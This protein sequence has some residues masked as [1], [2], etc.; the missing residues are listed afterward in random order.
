MKLI[1]FKVENFRSVKDS[2]WITCDDVTTLVGINE[3]G[4]SNL[5]LALW[6]MNPAS[7]GDIDP[8]HDMPVSSL[9]LMRK[10][11]DSTIFITAEF[12]LQDTAQILIDA[13]YA[14][15]ENTTVQISRYYDGNYSVDFPNGEPN[16]NL[17][18]DENE[19]N[20]KNELVDLIL[21]NLP[22]F[23]YYSH[24]GNLATRIYLPHAIKWLNGENVPGID[25]REDQVR[26]IQVLFKYVGLEPKE[27][28]ELGKEPVDKINNRPAQISKTQIETVADNK[29]KRSILLQSA[30]SK[31]TKEFKQW[32]QQGE[33]KFRFEADGDYFSIL[34]SDDK[35]PDEVSL[36]LRSTGLQWFLSF[37]LIFLVESQNK[38]KNAILLLDEAGLTLHPLAQKDLSRFFIE[39]SKTNQI[40]NTTHSPFIV[41]TNNIDRCK[42]VYLD[43]DGY[44][45]AS[46]DL[47]QGR[48]KLNEKS[49]YAVHAAL[50]LSV[51]DVLLQGCK[52][53][54]VE[55]PSDQIYLNMMKQI[56]IGQGKIN[57]KEELV[58]VPAGGVKG[59]SG[60][61]SILSGKN[62]ELPVVLVDSD[63]SGE[64]TK[65]KLTNNN[66]LYASEQSKILEVG[67]YVK[68]PNAEIEDLV[69]YKMLQRSIDKRFNMVDDPF[70]FSKKASLVPQ[71]EEFANKY[72]VD[73]EQGWKVE[74][75][76]KAKNIILQEDKID[77][78]TIDSWTK[79]FNDFLEISEE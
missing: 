18:A 28:L 56:L 6:K 20:D 9:S 4:K 38:H 14:V 33:Y 17:S 75:A 73:L 39:L 30:S 25:L 8:L 53:I 41:D 31:L 72:E 60:V 74:L 76:K 59:I 21:E 12:E 13:G 71:I 69:S 57:P 79:L 26:T 37:F 1:K 40:V 54:I 70:K 23:V 27:I 77:N 43:K 55:G 51:S 15:N 42:V 45:V 52:P 35:R 16:V 22:V 11:E 65:K 32:W 5:L 36:E 34:V 29:E 64:D 62:G 7:G 63:K 2:G 68:V 78:N 47:R 44:T 46:D 10:N 48:D 67:T 58:F 66:G 61:V 24:Y 3:A 19:G 49:I 50:G